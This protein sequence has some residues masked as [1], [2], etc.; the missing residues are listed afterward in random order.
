MYSPRATIESIYFVNVV[1]CSIRRTRCLGNGPGRLHV[2]MALASWQPQISHSKSSG[3]ALGY[4]LTLWTVWLLLFCRWLRDENKLQQVATGSHH[5]VCPSTKINNGC[6]N[7]FLCAGQWGTCLIRRPKR[8]VF[9][10]QGQG[11]DQIKVPG[12]GCQKC[13]KLNFN[14]IEKKL[15]KWYFPFNS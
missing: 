15:E 12:E 1:T 5:S 3:V 14:R 11:L 2:S 7:V 13:L 4:I 8:A 10:S 6:A 9:R